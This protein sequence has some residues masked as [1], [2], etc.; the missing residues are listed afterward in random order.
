[1]LPLEAGVDLTAP[2]LLLRVGVSV[3]VVRG[4]DVAGRIEVVRDRGRLVLQDGLRPVALLVRVRVPVV[5]EEGLLVTPIVPFAAADAVPVPAVGIAVECAEATAKVQ[6]I[7]VIVP[8]WKPVIIVLSARS[9][10]RTC[11]TPDDHRRPTAWPL[12]VLLL[13]TRSSRQPRI[14]RASKGL[15]SLPDKGVSV[16]LAL[17]RRLGGGLGLRTR[18]RIH[19]RRRRGAPTVRWHPSPSTLTLG[20]RSKR[21]VRARGGDGDAG[22]GWVRVAPAV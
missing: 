18:Q 11:G 10:L 12:P 22:K 16:P 2:V 17:V 4:G 5:G 21:H 7:W 14:S 19:R 1:M 6:S 15:R 3:L 9:R 8:V 20:S 13:R